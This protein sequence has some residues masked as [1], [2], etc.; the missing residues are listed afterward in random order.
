MTFLAIKSRLQAVSNTSELTS[1]VALRHQ[2]RRRS[3]GATPLNGGKHSTR[4]A[5]ADWYV[6]S[7]RTRPS[8]LL[9][10]APTSN[11]HSVDDRKG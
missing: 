1:E 4:G 11:F 9:T 7:N 2:Q 8:E 3:K 10:R 6:D 5:P